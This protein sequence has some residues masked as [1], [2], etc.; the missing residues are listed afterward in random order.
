MLVFLDSV[1]IIRYK[2]NKEEIKTVKHPCVY[3][4][5]SE[6]NGTLYI[7]STSNLVQRIYQ[8]KNE[9]IEGFTKKHN[10]KLLVYYEQHA[11]LDT[12]LIRENQMKLWKRKW[13]MNLIEKENPQW[14]D[15]YDSLL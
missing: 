11:T 3:M 8:H 12:A 15:L 10:V 9:V 5:A 7:G 2:N 1:N 4:L 14:L 6:R 13:K